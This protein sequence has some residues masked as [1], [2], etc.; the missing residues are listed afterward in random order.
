M[1]MLTMLV[2]CVDQGAEPVLRHERERPACELDAV[3]VFSP[4]AEELVKVC[5][6][7]RGVVR[8]T[9]L[10]QPLGAPMLGAERVRG[11]ERKGVILFCGGKTGGAVKSTTDS[12]SPRMEGESLQSLPDS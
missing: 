7:H 9:D 3:D 5:L 6:G 12:R 10:R 8:T 2:G 11:E 1:T 4:V